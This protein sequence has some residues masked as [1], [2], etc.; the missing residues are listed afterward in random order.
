MNT[1]KIID[2]KAIANDLCD[3]LSKKVNSLV[4]EHEI[5]PCLAVILVG[6]NP[7]SQVYVKNKGIKTKEVGMSSLEY[8]LPK[9]ISEK[10]LLIK[11]EELNKNKDINGILVQLPL[12]SHIDEKIVIN[13]ISSEK[14]V[15]GFHIINSGLLATGQKSTIPCTPKGCMIMLKNALGD[16]T[17]LHAVVVGR[18]NIVGK[19]MS[20]LLLNENCTVTVVHSKT[21]DIKKV[22]KQA[23]ILVAAVGIPKM[24][25]SSWLK[26]GV[27]VIDVGINRIVDEQGKS[28]LVGD[29][30]FQDALKVASFI[31]P[32][33]GGVGPMTIACLLQNTYEATLNQNLISL[34]SEKF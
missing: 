17:G 13:S 10:D 15:D 5:K 8:K 23:D 3:N 24:I 4:L 9:E 22:C 20:Q 31:S 16:L 30:D 26:T 34:N 21:N 1:T 18:S 6:D 14:D 11:I 2:G 12:P 29:V 25:D 32:V 7:A 33:P 28:K 19:P 27:T